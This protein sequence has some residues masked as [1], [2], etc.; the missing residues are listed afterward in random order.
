MSNKPKEKEIEIKL[1]FKNKE[2]VLSKLKT[3]KFVKKVAIHDVYYGTGENMSNSNSLTRIRDI[4]G[5]E[6]ELTFKSKAQDNNNVWHRVE[7]T[8]IIS[9]ADTMGKI[10]SH[11]N[12]NK[13]S[14]YQNIK[15]YYDVDGLEIVFADFTLP[16]KLIFMEIEGE[17]EE[18]I[19]KIL[20]ILGDSVKEAGEEIFDVFD[21]ARAE[22]N[23]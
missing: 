22:K 3:A 13:I 17:S 6:I 19:R 11:L 20:S 2:E 15:E 18:E 12:L 9:S 7:L 4:E 16:A 23:N 21:K 8:T 5:E 14:E 10:L 1:T